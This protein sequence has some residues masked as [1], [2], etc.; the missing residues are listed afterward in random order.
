MEEDHSNR[1][2]YKLRGAN[3]DFFT[4]VEPE[5]VNVGPADSGKTWAGC[6]KIH[7]ACA[8]IPKVQ[9]LLVRKE[10]NAL[11]GTI[12]KTFQRI[13]DGQPVRV[14]GGESAT[15]FIYPNGSVVWLGGMDNAESVLSAERDYIYV[16]EAASLTLND[17]EILSTRCSGR[18]AVV[19]HPQL[20]GDTNPSGAKHWLRERAKS[21][22]IRLLTSTHRDNPTIYEDDGTV[23]EDGQKRLAVLE[24]LS[25]VRRKR[26]LEGIWATAEGAVFDMFDANVHVCKRDASEMRVW[27]LAMD[28]GY[29]NP[30]VIL[31]IGADSDRRWH[32]FREFY[33]RGILEADVVSVAREWNTEKGC[34]CAAVD[35]AGAG[36]IASLCANGVNAIGGKGRILDGILAIQNRLAVQKG[37]VSLRFP[38]GRPRLTVDP[39]CTNTINEFESYMFKA[40]KDAPQDEFNHSMSAVR[41]LEDVITVGTGAFNELSTVSIPTSK[42]SQRSF[43]PRRYSPTR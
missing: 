17:W 18:A 26:L 37:D 15:R 4:S 42:L 29:T 33:K 41:Y 35:E 22:I 8:T 25:G 12:V 7:A 39:S 43:S 19:K 27:Y 30:A 21:G 36:L 6:L 13:I 3:L 10:F 1:V 2:E 38:Y 16:N 28:E 11:N 20:L 14:Y 23:T 32:I 24:N 34:E 5:C 40:G 9:A 31:L